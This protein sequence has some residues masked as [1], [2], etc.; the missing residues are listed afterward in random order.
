MTQEVNRGSGCTQQLRELGAGPPISGWE[1]ESRSRG[2]FL[3][4]GGWDQCERIRN[5]NR[6]NEIFFAEKIL[7]FLASCDYIGAV[8]DVGICI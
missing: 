5:L 8:L 3:S 7:R 2:G 1:N 6:G 4:P